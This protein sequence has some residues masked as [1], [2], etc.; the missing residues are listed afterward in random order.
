MSLAHRRCRR[1]HARER[2]VTYRRDMRE[3]MQ[4]VDAMLVR[5]GAQSVDVLD[6]EEADKFAARLT[7]SERRALE[8]CQLVRTAIAYAEMALEWLDVELS[9]GD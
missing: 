6:Y 7:G 2:L 9:H 4:S 1:N 5:H 8:K 3:W